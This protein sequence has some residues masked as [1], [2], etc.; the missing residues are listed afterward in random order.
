MADEL[1]NPDPFT[2]DGYDFYPGVDSPG[3]DIAQVGRNVPEAA[4]ACKKINGAIA[5]NT[6]GLVKCKLR[7]A[8]EWQSIEGD[9][10]RE[11]LYIKKQH[12]L[13]DVM[14]RF[15]TPARRSS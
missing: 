11:G 4:R 14:R 8:T 2:V 12:R 6:N 1:I 3:H 7:P 13:V 15:L 9:A 5:F 10:A